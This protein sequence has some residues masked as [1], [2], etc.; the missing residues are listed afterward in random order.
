MINDKL[1]TLIVLAREKNYTKTAELRNITQPAVTQHIQSLE[2]HF[3]IK[4][5]I[6]KGKELVITPEGETLIKEARKLI[7]IDKRIK[8]KLA[9]EINF[10]ASFINVSPSGVITNSFP[11]LMKILIPK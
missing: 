4:I 7:S 6:K 9:R 11:F 10:R 2:N 8:E 5:F 1:Y 3:G